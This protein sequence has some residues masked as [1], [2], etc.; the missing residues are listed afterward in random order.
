[1]PTPEELARQTIDRML[2]ASG[3]EVQDRKRMNIAAGLGVAVREFPLDSGPVDYLLYADGRA[4]G[5]IE[6]KPA[7]HTLTGVEL[8]SA[9]YRDGLPPEFPSWAKPDKPLPFGYESTGAVTQFTSALDP[10]PRS[11][12]VFSFH[13]PED[14]IRIASLDS[15]LRTRLRAMPA[16]AQGQLWDKQVT[17]IENLERSMACRY[18]RTSPTRLALACRRRTKNELFCWLVPLSPSWD[19]PSTRSRFP[20]TPR[21]CSDIP[22]FVAIRTRALSVRIMHETSILHAAFHHACTE[23]QQHAFRLHAVSCLRCLRDCM[24]SCTLEVISPHTRV[25]RRSHGRF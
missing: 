7:G 5:V 17:A 24:T 16:L 9:R 10:Y 23:W 14:L 25:I 11:R 15:Q 12:G 22:D 13:R 2:A 4:I 8:Q 1:M 21:I 3:W 6:A 18:P 20:C 19:P